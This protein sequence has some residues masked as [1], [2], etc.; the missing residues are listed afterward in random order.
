MDEAF[1]AFRQVATLSPSDYSTRQFLGNEFQ[2]RDRIPEAIEIYN[3]VT[4]IV[5][6]PPQVLTQ[7][8][9][10]L[11]ELYEKNGQK[12]EALAQYR[13]TLKAEPAN[14][15]ATAAVKRLGG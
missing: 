9:L 7:A 15:A 8:R 10:R 14:A 1:A 12:A 6:V 5:G 11:G 3:E 4:R 2:K 13:E